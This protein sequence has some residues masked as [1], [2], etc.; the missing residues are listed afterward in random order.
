[1][2]SNGNGATALEL[3]LNNPQTTHTLNR[4]LDRIDALEASVGRLADIIEQ[5]PAF[6]AMAGD[7]VDETHRR[8]AANGV[9]LEERLQ[10]AITM[11]EKLTAPK[12]VNKIEQMM[13]D[14]DQA[15]HFAAMVGDMVDETQRRAAANGI[16]IEQRLG[17]GLAIAEKLTRPQ[18]VEQLNGL[19]EM[20]DTAPGFIAMLGDIADEAYRNAM[21]NGIDLESL[22]SQG[23]SAASKLSVLMDSG[24]L[25]DG[26]V[27]VVGAAGKALADA[28][29]QTIE[30]VG[31]FGLL[32][33]L[34]DP[35]TQRALGFLL[36]VGSNLG[37]ELK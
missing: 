29:Q 9:D 22:I 26:A 10:T 35:D 1:M 25:D 7:V 17:A 5:V 14:V 6:T 31:M 3:R 12:M 4:L 19:L 32:G 28:S 21:A 36:N 18:M 34:R 33:A 2:E 20:A 13:T 30:P 11:A 8:A 16:D 24:I 37:K 15:P 27:R 23:T